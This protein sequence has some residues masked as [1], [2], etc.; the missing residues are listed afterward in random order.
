M[1]IQGKIKKDVKVEL[2][3]EYISTNHGDNGYYHL[4]KNNDW[5]FLVRRGEGNKLKEMHKVYQNQQEMIDKMVE[6]NIKI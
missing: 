2:G 1:V 3:I 6:L 5:L 4:Y